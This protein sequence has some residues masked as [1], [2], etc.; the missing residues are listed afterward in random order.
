MYP[1]HRPYTERPYSVYPRRGE[2]D[3]WRKREEEFLCFF[4]PQAIPGYGRC[5]L[6]VYTFPQRSLHARLTI[7]GRISICGTAAVSV[8]P[9]RRETSSLHSDSELVAG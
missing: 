2:L 9:P 5:V 3:R 8:R 7:S 6:K 4:C 1:S